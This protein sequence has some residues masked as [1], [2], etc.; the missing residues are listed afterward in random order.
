MNKVGFFRSIHL[1]FVIIYV[2]LILVAMQIVSVYFVRQLE[3]T[4]NN[5]FKTTIEDSVNLLAYYLEEQIVKER[6]P[7]EGDLSLEEDVNRLLSDYNSA[8]INEV[9]VIEG[10][11]LKVLGTSDVENRS[12]LGQKLPDPLVRLAISTGQ[13]Q[14]NEF[15]NDAGQR[16]W[17]LVKP[18]MQ[19]DEVLG[20]IHVS[21]KIENVYDQLR[22]INNIFSTGTAIALALTAVLSV[23]LA[24]TITRPI[25][26]MRKQALAMAKG[27]YSRKVKIYGQDEIG[28]L[29]MTFNS[30][31]R[32]LQ[33]AQAT[34]E[35]ERRKL[36]SVLTY[37]TDGV[38]ATDRKGRVILINEPAADMLNV[39]RETV[40]STSI[41]SLLGLEE[42][43]TF[44]ELL[45]ERE[46]IILDYSDHKEN[47]ILRANISVIQKET[48]FIN[49]LITV[50]HD[51]TEQEKIEEERREFVANVSHELRTPL[52]TM[53][54][55]LEALADGAWQDK[56]LAP[57]FLDVTQT[58]TE[59]M[60]RLVN[61]LL[62]LS[63][64]DSKDYQF[65]KEWIDFVKFYHRIIDRFEFTKQQNVTFERRL[66]NHADFVEID[67]DKLT[68][69]MDNI[70]SN[71]LKYSPE[72]GKV[73]FSIEERDQFLIISI[74]DEGMGIPKEN[75]TKIFDRFYRVDK[76]R[77]RKLGG[78]GLGL[79]IAKEMVEAHGGEIWADSVDGKGTTISFSLP[80]V[81][82]EEDD[83]E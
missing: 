75:L 80:Y 68:Q 4:L 24:Q 82:T 7:E 31:T 39:S 37:M 44:E 1:K 12:I 77:T 26:D 53:R 36:S 81:R 50:L 72:G 70:I 28:Q 34:T 69:V 14:N 13:E 32:K 63:K 54:S 52:T 60:I 30:L 76:A 78:T 21:A 66:P 3:T 57:N 2:L 8:D 23:L 56:N 47:L 67:A 38:I 35:G 10:D 45:E 40:L 58:E 25:T 59:R 62:Q 48:G 17:V 79:A 55:Y 64:M 41:V 9:Q 43:Y 49:G 42:D 29:A 61:D 65:K 15:I 83:W 22:E 5:N 11:S 33:E 51:I 46:S 20:A 71:A 74:S 16:I 6:F 73:T 18:I 27:N 19:D